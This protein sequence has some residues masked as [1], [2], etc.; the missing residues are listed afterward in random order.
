MVKS[1][2]RPL[3]LGQSQYDIVL[4]PAYNGVAAFNLVNRM[5]TLNN[6]IS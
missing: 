5:F 4:L 3:N 6:T 2:T 1:V